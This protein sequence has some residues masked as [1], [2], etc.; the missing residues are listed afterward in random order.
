[1]ALSPADYIQRRLCPPLGY[2]PLHPSLH[3]LVIRQLLCDCK[4]HSP[5]DEKTI[6]NISSSSIST[7]L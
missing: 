4:C 7:I 2:S 5:N 6:N 1:V 3:P